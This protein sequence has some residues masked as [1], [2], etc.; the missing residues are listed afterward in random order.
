[1]IRVRKGNRSRTPRPRSRARHPDREI[2]RSEPMYGVLSI[3]SRRVIAFFAFLPKTFRRR[4]Y[5]FVHFEAK[6]ATNTPRFDPTTTTVTVRRARKPSL[7]AARARRHPCTARDVFARDRG[8]SP[9]GGF[10]PP[11]AG[12]PSATRGDAFPRLPSRAPTDARRACPP[13]PARFP[14]CR[15]RGPPRARPRTRSWTSWRRASWRRRSSAR[16][17]ATRACSSA[18]RARPDRGRARSRAS[19]ARSRERRRGGRRRGGVPHGRLSLLHEGPEIEQRRSVPGRTRGSDSEG[20]PFT[21]DAERFV[22]RVAAAPGALRRRRRH[23]R[24]RVRPRRSRPD[25]K[26]DRNKGLAQDR[27]RGGQLRVTAGRPVAYSARRGV[28]DESWFVDVAVDDAMRRASRR[29]TSPSA[30]RPRRRAA[31]RTATTG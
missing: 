29:D 18:S 28:L 19:G 7:L 30:E 24:P 5:L 6:N 14:A 20:S 4:V 26:R 1:M 9:R 16:A 17:T 25:G 27:A 3:A 31:G 15:S 12:D 11:R 10:S 21:F 8:V 22:A 23:A 2:Q 13:P